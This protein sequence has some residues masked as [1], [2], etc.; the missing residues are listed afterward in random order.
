MEHGVGRSFARYRLLRQ[1]AADAVSTTWFATVDTGTAGAPG[2]ATDHFAVRIAERVNVDDQHA[3]DVAQSFLSRA[4]QAGAIDH[5]AIVR[6]HDL[7]IADG[8]PFVVTTFVRAVPLGELLAHGGTITE[9]AALAMFAQLA[10]AL[11]AAHRNSVVHGALSP[12]TVWVGPGAGEGVAYVAY[13][14]GFGTSV[15]LRDHLARE[16]RGELLEDILYVAPEQLR[17]EAVTGHSDQYSLACAL[18]HTLT[19]Q[20]PFQR[21][22]RSKLYGAHLFAPPPAL[23]D[24]DPAL[25]QETSAALERGMAKRPEERHATCG[26]L[27]HEAL[28]PGD[29]RRPVR[30]VRQLTAGLDRAGVSPRLR[31]SWMSVGAAA[32]AVVVVGLALWV[33]LRPASTPTDTADL[34]DADAEVAA[35]IDPEPI[36]EATTAAAVSTSVMWASEPVL[37]GPVT[38]LQVRRGMAVASG[39]AGLA[40]VDIAGGQVRWAAEVDTE[41]VAVTRTVVAYADGAL[42]ALDLVTGDELWSRADAVPTASLHASDE[43]V[44]GVGETDQ[45]PEVLGVD[46]ADGDELWHLHTDSD[47]PAASLMVTATHHHVT[48]ALQGDE[49]LAIRHG[50]ADRT[51]MGRFQVNGTAWRV[52]I[53]DPWPVLVTGDEGVTAASTT[54]AVCRFRESDGQQQWCATVPGVDVEQPRILDTGERVFVTTSEV[55]AAFDAVSGGQLWSESPGS[56]SNR[57]AAGRSAVAV[58]DGGGAVRVVDPRSGDTLHEER[59]LGDVTSLEVSDGAV[60]VGVADGSL[61]RISV[62]AAG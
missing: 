52:D 48:Y 41:D 49:V 62:D 38:R 15:L 32:A 40:A 20:P 55:V 58:A 50:A 31:R 17:G 47:D 45:S 44:V 22:H 18:W 14:T 28:P 57:V 13:L 10:G 37:S 29:D 2:D 5:P 59:D 1:L 19:G 12:R 26:D 56:P 36:T 21:E 3:V 4:Q 54:G 24:I 61:A 43:M 35:Q 51:A 16:P 60:F 9:S 27:V 11:D 23:V 30:A 7:G 8:H 46:P 34:G 33:M 53:D 42:T 6:P 25:S 39:D